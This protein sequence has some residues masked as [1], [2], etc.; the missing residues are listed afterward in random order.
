M[1]VIFQNWQETDMWICWLGETIQSCIFRESTSVRNQGVLLLVW[2]CLGGPALVHQTVEIRQLPGRMLPE[3]CS[4]ETVPA[5]GVVI[6]IKA[7][8]VSGRSKRMGPKGTIF[9]Y[10]QK[11]SSWQWRKWKNTWLIAVVRV[12]IKKECPGK[13]INQ[14]CQIVVK[15]LFLIYVA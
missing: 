15:P 13:K 14:H 12:D 6:L 1:S 4:A 3:H 2:V 11:K 9:E 7:F 10:A 5:V 8:N